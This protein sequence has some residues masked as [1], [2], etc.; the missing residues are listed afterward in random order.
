MYSKKIQIMD[1]GFY[2]LFRANWLFFKLRFRDFPG[3]N[4]IDA[5][6]NTGLH[7][8]RNQIQDFQGANCIIQI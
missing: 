7:S 6:R 2:F 1:N 8:G 4:A 3:C 5:I